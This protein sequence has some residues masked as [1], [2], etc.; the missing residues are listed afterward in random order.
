MA[1]ESRSSSKGSGYVTI[2]DE[3]EGYPLSLF[4]IPKHYSEDLSHVLIPKGLID[5]RVEKLALDIKQDIGNEPLVCLCI[6]KGG[7]QFFGDLIDRLK[8]LNTVTEKPLPLKV[9]FV[10]LKSY[11]ND[12]STEQVQ[13]VGGDDLQSLQGKNVLIVEDIVGKKVRIFL[14]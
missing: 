14:S 10:R 2:H 5:D 9:D 6:L 1:S 13:I 8:A 11:V 4:C 7:Y 12:K 3:M